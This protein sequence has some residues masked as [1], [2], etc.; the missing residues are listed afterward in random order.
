MMSRALLH[1]AL[2]IAASTVVAQFHAG[3]VQADDAPV[4]LGARQM[5]GV[6][7]SAAASAEAD[8]AAALWYPSIRA[9]SDGAAA[10]GAT[11]N[12]SA[13]LGPAFGADSSW[14]PPPLTGMTAQLGSQTLSDSGTVTGGGISRSVTSSGP[15]TT[16]TSSASAFG[17]GTSSVFVSSTTA[18]ASAGMATSAFS[19]SSSRSSSFSAR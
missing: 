10:F 2:A 19:S 18:F 5:D 14:S 15:G 16:S 9:G 7:A 6:T 4:V 8:E 1:V 11:S 12:E 13:G 17:P 3:S